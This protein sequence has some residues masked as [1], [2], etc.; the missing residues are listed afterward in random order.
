M[1]ASQQS[2][3]KKAVAPL[4]K[5]AAVES[6]ADSDVESIVDSDQSDDDA[7]D[8]ISA[9]NNDSLYSADT[10][11]GSDRTKKSSSVTNQSRS[12]SRW[13]AQPQIDIHE[14]DLDRALT[15]IDEESDTSAS[16]KNSDVG[17][18]SEGESS[19]SS[20]NADVRL[21]STASTLLIC[22]S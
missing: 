12:S 9:L 3:A 7:T 21:I 4:K 1:R 5:P 6:S 16:N 18:R 11:A 15:T 19:D 17:S 10:Y 14:Q 13:N 8:D 20:S 2:S 22:S